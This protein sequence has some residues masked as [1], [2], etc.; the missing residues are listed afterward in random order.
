MLFDVNGNVL[1]DVSNEPDPPNGRGPNVFEQTATAHD[2]QVLRCAMARVSE[3]TP[4]TVPLSFRFIDEIR[5]Y[6]CL[7]YRSGNVFF[8][9]GCLHQCRILPF[10]PDM[11][12]LV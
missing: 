6:R 10:M 4:L 5:H 3:S 12:G 9:G 2:K 7:I 8:L 11:V 1:V